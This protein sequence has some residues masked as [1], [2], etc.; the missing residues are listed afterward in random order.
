MRLNGSVSKVLSR[1]F[2]FKIKWV[3]VILISHLTRVHHQQL[4]VVWVHFI[5]FQIV[6]YLI[7]ETLESFKIIKGL[8]FCWKSPYYTPGA[9]SILETCP[10]LNFYFIYLLLICDGFCVPKPMSMN[11]RVLER[12]WKSFGKSFV[13]SFIAH[14]SVG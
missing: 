2:G 6:P 11:G 5:I 7:V 10:S 3:L 12:F 14:A 4:V 13:K 8:K 9:T 1:V